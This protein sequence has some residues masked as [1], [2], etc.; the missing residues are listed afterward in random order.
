MPPKSYKG[1]K[2]QQ[3]ESTQ[4]VDEAKSKKQTPLYRL[5]SN[6]VAGCFAYPF[7]WVKPTQGGTLDG[8]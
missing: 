2:M 1:P 3:K 8:I 4:Q 5:G 6:R 7:G